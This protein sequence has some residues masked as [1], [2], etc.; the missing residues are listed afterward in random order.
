MK[1]EH[2]AGPNPIDQMKVVGRPHD[3]IDGPL[4]TTGRALYAYEHTQGVETA[5][6]GYVVG[7]AIAKGRIRAIDDAAVLAS[8]GVL[9]VVTARNAG[10]LGKGERNTA[11]LLA[12]PEV[13]HY[14]QAIA[15]VVA[16]PM[17]I[18]C[19][20]ASTSAEPSLRSVSRA[21]PPGIR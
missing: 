2:P 7:S 13:Q 9:G 10:E 14:H 15:V 11:A 21:A 19:A 6:Y 17:P 3:R 8:P 20:A 12:G 4:K 5:A 1:F 16:V 18:S